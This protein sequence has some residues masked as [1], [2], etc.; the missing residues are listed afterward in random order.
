MTR[1]AYF[2]QGI[3][4]LEYGDSL[5]GAA[6]FTADMTPKHSL[7]AAFVRSTEA[8]ARIVSID[9]TEALAV[10]GVIGVWTG[11]EIVG[12][13]LKPRTDPGRA[14]ARFVADVNWVAPPFTVPAMA[15]D[16]TQYV[17][18]AV[19][20]VVANSRY[21]AEDGAEAVMV[22]YDPLEAAIDPRAALEADAPI[23]NPGTANN[24]AASLSIEHG[25]P[26]AADRV[27]RTVTIEHTFYIARQNATPMECRGAVAI[28]RGDEVDVWV[29]SQSP[30]IIERVI[31]EAAGWADGTVHAQTPAMGGAFGQKTNSWAE[32]LVV[33][34]L[35]KELGQPVAWIEDRYENL[36]AAPQSRD[37][38]HDVRLVVDDEG[39]IL[40]WEDDFLVDFGAQCF[41][42]AGVAGNTAV[43]LLGPYAVPYVR[44]NGRGAFTNK[45]PTAQYRGAGRPE[46][47]FAL[48]RSLDLAAR[49]LGIGTAKIREQ[50]LLGL[51]DLPHAKPVIYRDGASIVYDGQD[52]QAVARAA[53]ELIPES[54]VAELKRQAGP[55]ERIGMG[56]IAYVEATGRGPEPDTVRVTFDHD[57]ILTVHTGGA[58]SGQF[59]LTT[60]AQI[61]A[62]ASGLPMSA[63]KVV[64]SAPSK[65]PRATPTAAS[66]TAV[67]TGNATR[68][69]AMELMEKVAAWLETTLDVGPLRQVAEGYQAEGSQS[70]V[71][72]DEVAALLRDGRGPDG[73]TEI[74]VI[75]SFAPAASTWT[76]GVHVAVVGVDVGLGATRVL[77]Y[78]VAEETG[79][80]INPRVVEGQVLGG[81]AQGIGEALLE[82]ITYS[83]TGQPTTTTLM[84]YKIPEAE[85]VPVI[86]LAHI[87]VPSERNP[88]GVKGVGESGV[89]GGAAVIAAA[90]ENALADL[91]ITIDRVPVTADYLL[92]LILE[93]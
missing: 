42:R 15:V 28:P 5:R 56:I 50:N 45:T 35:A 3:E 13:R 79:P 61:A 69:G 49:Q 33:T 30:F 21:E 75:G 89:I 8:R 27:T 84:D 16:V 67:V 65:V 20:I 17:G 91:P 38:F 60:L 34:V 1:A 53:L 64:T 11:A 78:A 52:Y 70:I 92:E 62:D 26:H 58:P 81:V 22:D 88:L 80:A 72:W 19:A 63:V 48:E 46:A 39:H 59:H 24:L 57:G 77:R 12:S 9:T 47:A 18:Q 55:D 76:M 2:G 87:E 82:A 44:I 37:Q 14:E 40:S 85:D 29:S 7:H 68:S 90:I 86:R 74:H 43:H 71:S 41:I 54:E 32:E 36:V 51:D 23:V 25:D 6:R 10:P 4:P 93:A 83:D 66:R 73:A 31:H